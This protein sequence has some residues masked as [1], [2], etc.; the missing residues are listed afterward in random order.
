MRYVE[1]EGFQNLGIFETKENRISN[2]EKIE[3]SWDFCITYADTCIRYLH[4]ARDGSKNCM[5]I[6]RVKIQFI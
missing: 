2:K 6:A 5:N 4:W 3:P 1:S